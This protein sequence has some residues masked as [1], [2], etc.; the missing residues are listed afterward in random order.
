M[1][2]DELLKA[3]TLL[4]GHR[5]EAEANAVKKLLAGKDSVTLQQL[6]Q[7]VIFRVVLVNRDVCRA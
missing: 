7:Y 6:E 5:S 3:M 1:S 2:K 4:R